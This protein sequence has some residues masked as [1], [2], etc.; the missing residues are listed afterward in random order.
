MKTI[1]KRQIATLVVMLMCISPILAQGYTRGH[2]S[3]GW[4]YG[5][6]FSTGFADKPS[7][8][9]MYFD[10]GCYINPFLS[11]GGFVSFQTNYEYVPRATYPVG[12][13]GAVTTDQQHGMHQIPFGAYVRY[14]LFT[15]I[16]QPFFGAKVGVNYMYSYSDVPTARYYDDTWGFHISPEIGVAIF[17]FKHNRLGF[18]IAGYYSY[19]TNQSQ[20]FS[21]DMRGVNNAGF[22]LGLIF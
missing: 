15:G 17:P 19:S 7:G 20:I 4:Q 2:F 12:V 8:Y 13:T 21:Y 6:P 3:G 5:S 22:R 9:G 16:F 18:N 14:R 11:I 10:G 1:I